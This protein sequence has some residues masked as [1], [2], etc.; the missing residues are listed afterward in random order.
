MNNEENRLLKSIND[1]ESMQMIFWDIINLDIK[2]DFPEEYKN[3][4]N[5][6]KTAAESLH[7]KVDIETAKEFR[8]CVRMNL[9][10]DY[11]KS[12][13]WKA[14]Y[15]VWNFSKNISTNMRTNIKRKAGQCSGRKRR[16]K[17]FEILKE[18]VEPLEEALKK[19]Q[20]VNYARRYKNEIIVDVVDKYHDIIS[21]V[22]NKYTLWG[23][24]Y[25]FFRYYL[26]ILIRMLQ[27]SSTV[28]NDFKVKI[29]K[30]KLR[31]ISSREKSRLGAL[32]YHSNK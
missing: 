11:Q 32:K 5:E 8:Q 16:E 22:K 23:K 2:S 15:F 28:N 1:A 9:N 20:D 4:L 3:M 13:F 31:S 30:R 24:E 27:N 25:D 7:N 6:M 18:I 17:Q 10:M 19:L 21:N 26:N 12:D 29:E 14:L